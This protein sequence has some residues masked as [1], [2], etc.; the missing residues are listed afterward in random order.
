MWLNI[1]TLGP[2]LWEGPCQWGEQIACRHTWDLHEQLFSR[3]SGAALC[4]ALLPPLASNDTTWASWKQM[5]VMSLYNSYCHGCMMSSQSLI[6]DVRAIPGSAGNMQNQTASPE[7]YHYYPEWLQL[8]VGGA[9]YIVSS[10]YF[11][12]AASLAMLP[13]GLTQY[14]IP[15]HFHRLWK[16]IGRK[17]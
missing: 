3:A 10:Q 13:D 8:Q 1:I 5:M 17:L 11:H 12:T 2:M 9:S 15:L 6:L 16:K 7:P 4:W 14:K